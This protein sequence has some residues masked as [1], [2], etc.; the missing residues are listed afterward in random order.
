M[1]WIPMTDLFALTLVTAG[2]MGSP[3]A[4][5]PTDAEKAPKPR[6][7]RV[8][9]V[10]R[11]MDAFRG[12]KAATPT[13]Q[14]TGE[15]VV[16]FAGIDKPVA[17]GAA[18]ELFDGNDLARS[19]SDVGKYGAMERGLLRDLAW[20][21]DPSLGPKLLRGPAAAA[22]RRYFAI[23]RGDDPRGLYDQIEIVGNETLD[24]RPVTKLRMTPAT[25]KPDVWFVAGGEVA[26]VDI[27]LPAPEAD[28]IPAQLHFAQWTAIEGRRFAKQRILA[29]GK[30]KV[31]TTWQEI[32]VGKAID[33][34]KFTPP[35]AV[36]ALQKKGGDD[37]DAAT[38][39]TWQIVE[40]S[41]QA[42]ASIRVR[43]A[44]KDISAQLAKLLPEVGACLR[45]AGVQ[46]A[47]APFTRY[48]A[49]TDDEVEIEAGIP[50]QKPFAEQGRVKNST[51]PGGKL[52]TYWHVG[53]YDKLTEAHAAVRAHL[54]AEK[55]EARGG[56]WEVY[57]TD[58]GMVPDPN[59]WRT[60]LFA[61]IP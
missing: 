14:F 57:W 36:V 31:T 49:E 35:A 16:T 23:L 33:A 45:A 43:V 21:A 30:A 53:P 25:G 24:Q 2:A 6:D 22:A 29:M 55:L 17:K 4:Q 59:R 13:L 10:L 52:L 5:E 42:V 41:E 44:K 54:A 15:Y 40:R 3:S 39:A 11:E 28:L 38:G 56:L 12:A 7:E 46:P 47:G 18:L 19:T 1:K 58:P 37:A 61:P 48:H 27:E 8:E 60:Q 20:E 32:A 34:A 50:V 9:A 26:R 51:L